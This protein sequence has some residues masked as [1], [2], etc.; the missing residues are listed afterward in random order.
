MYRRG[1]EKRTPTSC[2]KAGIKIHPSN[3]NDSNNNKQSQLTKPVSYLH[4]TL[5]SLDLE[6]DHYSLD[7]IYHLFNISENKLTEDTLKGAKRIVLK[8]HPDKSQLDSKYFL[9]FSKAYKRLFSVYEFQNKSTNKKYK[10]E[11]FFEESNKNILNNMFEQNKELKDTKNFNSWFNQ[12][13]EKHRIDNPNEEGYGDWLK[14]DEDFISIN[15]NVT[16]GNMNEVFEQKKKQ[17]QDVTVYTGVTDMFA[18]SLGGSLLDGKGD[19]STDEYTDLRQAYTQ[20]LIP[21]TMDD[22]NKI[23]K[24]NNVSEYKAHRERVNIT[25]LTKEE[26]E[27]QLLKQQNTHDKHS[28]AL[29][30]KY[31]Q[32]SEKVKQKQQLFWGDI[33]QLSSW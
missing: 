3:N 8:M 16:K 31:A 14:S 32:E 27:R 13:F 4:T 9:F 30:F 26:S 19:F 23:Q 12:A 11:D 1:L 2:P 17:I 21:V 33:K 24:F 10:D 5:N 25:P 28:A 22:Y 20:T 15:E 7:D 18:S 29:A 6:L